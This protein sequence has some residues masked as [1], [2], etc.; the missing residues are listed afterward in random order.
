MNFAALGTVDFT[1]SEISVYPNPFTEILNVEVK[2]NATLSI[3]DMSGKRV[4]IHPL[5]KGRNEINKAELQ[6]GVYVYQIKNAKGEMLSS[7]KIIKK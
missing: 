1:K 5:N 4:S 6:S 3:F 2:E 7:G